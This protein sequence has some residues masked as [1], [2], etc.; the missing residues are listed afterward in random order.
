MRHIV[1][2]KY[3][4]TATHDQI[5]KVTAA[6][7]ELKNTIPGIVA[8]EHGINDSPEQKN[9]G[10]T[11]VYMFTF[12]DAAARDEYLPHPKHKEFGQ[13]LE[14]LDILEDAFVIDYIP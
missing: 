2:F 3:K 9:L 4:P 6:L 8:F 1:I 7:A 11:H 14:K 5:E 12:E 13:M 10:Y